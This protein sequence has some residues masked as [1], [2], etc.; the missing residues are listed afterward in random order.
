M[1]NYK[2]QKKNPARRCARHG[3]YSSSSSWPAPPDAGS[4]SSPLG[5]DCVCDR[6]GAARRDRLVKLLDNKYLLE[7]CE[8]YGI[9]VNEN[10]DNPGT[11]IKNKDGTLTEVTNEDVRKW[12]DELYPLE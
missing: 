5:W 8:L 7:L 12:F 6:K 9:E 3:P 2:K 10:S 4:A 1:N 11:F